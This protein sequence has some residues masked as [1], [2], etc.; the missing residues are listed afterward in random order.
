VNNAPQFKIR[1][2]ASCVKL[3]RKFHYKTGYKNQQLVNYC[4]AEQGGFNGAT[5]RFIM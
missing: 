1:K 4:R 3:N 2:L 5:V